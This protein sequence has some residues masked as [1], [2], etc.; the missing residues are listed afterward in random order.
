MI[1]S[2]TS[3]RAL[4]VNRDSSNICFRI[5]PNEPLRYAQV[6]YYADLKARGKGAIARE[7]KDIDA[8]EET[9]T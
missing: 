3:Q 6:W 1:G 8:D 5:L 4:D 7:F 9:R 2:H